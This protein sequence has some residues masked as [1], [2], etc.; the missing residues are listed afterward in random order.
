[1][2]TR[3]GNPGMEPYGYVVNVDVAVHRDGSYL[4]IERAETEEHAA[5]LLSFPGGKLEDPPDDEDAVLATARREVGEEVGVDVRD[6]SYVL[7]TVFTSDTGSSVLN[8]VV[9]GEY[10]GGEAHPREPEEVAAVHW[11]TR[12]EATSRPDLPSFVGDY[13]S[14]VADARTG[15]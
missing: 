6:L 9:T 15:G 4:F 2:A 12:A 14:A 7:S 5:G 11:L 3:P 1:M 13:L 10:A 8:V